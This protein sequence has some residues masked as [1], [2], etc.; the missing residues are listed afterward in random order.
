MSIFGIPLFMSME[1]Y[2]EFITVHFPNYP[3]FVSSDL[4]LFTYFVINFMYIFCIVLFIKFFYK[5]CIF[6]KNHLF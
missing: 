1:Y 4:G 2:I 6:I 3:T 5:I